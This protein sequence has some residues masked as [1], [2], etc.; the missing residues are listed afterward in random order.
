SIIENKGRRKTFPA[1]KELDG[2]DQA[3]TSHPAISRAQHEAAAN[4]LSLEEALRRHSDLVRSIADA[5]PRFEAVRRLTLIEQSAGSPLFVASN[6]SKLNVSSIDGLEEGRPTPRATPLIIPS[7]SSHL[8]SMEQIKIADSSSSQTSPSRVEIS[9]QP[10]QSLQE[11]PKTGLSSQWKPGSVDGQLNRTDSTISDLLLEDIDSNNNA[12]GES[13]SAEPL[14]SQ[15]RIILIRRRETQRLAEENLKA[16]NQLGPTPST[17]SSRDIS[18][19]NN[20]ASSSGDT[21]VQVIGQEMKNANHLLH[22]PLVA[23]VQGKSSLQSLP[24]VASLPATSRVT[25]SMNGRDPAL[26]QYSGPGKFLDRSS[27]MSSMSPEQYNCNKRSRLETTSFSTRNE[28]L[29]SSF[30]SLFI[31]PRR[32]LKQPKTN[33]YDIQHDESSESKSLERLLGDKSNQRLPRSSQHS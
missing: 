7:P 21:N 5:E 13:S 17:M 27:N 4:L 32:S 23:S 30:S 8:Q 24:R 11:V 1:N 33:L 20:V 19:F 25:E 2:Q 6:D 31:P 26:I 10:I 15:D 18:R 29:H 16:A 28:Y 14:F 3:I 9:R 22:V 12:E